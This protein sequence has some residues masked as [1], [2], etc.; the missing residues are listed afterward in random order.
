MSCFLTYF[1]KTKTKI[2][3]LVTGNTTN[4]MKV[5]VPWQLLAEQQK[6]FIADE[7]LPEGVHIREPSKMHNSEIQILC[8]TLQERQTLGKH[9]L[10]FQY[11]LPQHQKRK[12]SQQKVEH[13]KHP[14]DSNKEDS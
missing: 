13:H 10:R 8:Q 14:D 7:Y 11:V 6:K 3:I 1:W 5:A 9:V 4:N 12:S 2:F